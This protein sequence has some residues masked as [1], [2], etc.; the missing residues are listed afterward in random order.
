MRAR[1]FLF[2][3][4]V[5]GGPAL[6]RAQGGPPLATDD[7]GTVEAGHWEVNVA[8]TREH[9]SG[10]T[11]EEL[12]L[13]D[14]NYGWSERV[15]FKLEGSWLRLSGDG[16]A[17][18]AGVSDALVGVKWRFADEEKAGVAASTYPQV[19]FPLGSSSS[20]RGVTS[21]GT[22]LILPV[23][24]QKNFGPLAANVDFGYAANNQE[25]D[26]WFAG[27]ALGHEFSTHWELLAELHGE[28]AVGVRGASLLCNLG[29]R[30]PLA[31]HVTLLFSLGRELYNETDARAT[32]SY[33]GLQ[34]TR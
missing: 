22:G 25:D 17:S 10:A 27:L 33:L 4:L 2:L 1:H 6:L 30:I 26:Q 34:L 8:W 23:E 16:Q 11:A 3:L 28:T 19:G 9:R 29:T 20:H 31:Q 14:I 21:G 7:P 13:L 18:R 24:L 5:T 32:V 12:P 15:Q